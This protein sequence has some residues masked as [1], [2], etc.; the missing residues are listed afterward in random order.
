MEPLTEDPFRRRGGNLLDVHPPLARCDQH[1]RSGGAIDDDAQ[2]Q[3]ACDATPFLDEH[4]AHDLACRPGLDGDQR[5]TQET[6][7]RLAC[8]L[9]AMHDLDAVLRRVVLD[10]PFASP[11]GMD[12][13]L[14]HG[15]SAAE[16][17]ECVDRRLR[18]IGHDASGHL[19]AR[20]AKDLLGLVF[21]DFHRRVA[22]G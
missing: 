17:M 18:R 9:R 1:G 20:L 8:L 22:G 16:F 15:Q 5:V 14:D 11:A 21:V 10:R 3:F 19:D 4:A 12:L 6:V 7:C 2:V 13:G